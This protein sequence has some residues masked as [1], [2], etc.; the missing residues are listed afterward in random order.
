MPPKKSEDKLSELLEEQLRPI[1]DAL[2]K[3]ITSEALETRLISLEEKL[4]KK[5]NDQ[6]VEIEQLKTWQNQLE[7][8]VAILENLTRLQE[9]KSDDV[10]Q[11]GRRFCLRIN[12]IPLKTREK[13]Q[14]LRERVHKEITSMGL[15]IPREA[16]DRIHRTGKKFESD[17]RDEDGNVTGVSIKQQVIMHFTGWR[18][19]TMVYRARKKSKLLRFKVDLTRRRAKLLAKAKKDTEGI[20]QIKYVFADI[21]CR[22]N[23]RFS[24]DSFKVFN[25]KTELAEIIASCDER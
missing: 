1:K 21:N 15:N 3:L 12:G 10:E 11:Y 17:D 18:S 8:R 23:V 13:E 14:D 9:I 20:D 7:G 4:V 6:A 22:L 19:R 5:I 25:T 16:I 2:S 24:D